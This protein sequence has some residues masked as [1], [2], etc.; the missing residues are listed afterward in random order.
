MPFQIFQDASNSKSSKPRSQNDAFPDLPTNLKQQKLKTYISNCCF[1]KFSKMPQTAKAQHLHPKMKPF[2]IF[3]DASN[4]TSSKPTSQ[5][6]CLSKSSKMPQAAKAQ[7]LHPK[8]ICFQIFQDAS[9]NKSSKSISQNIAF[10]KLP[11]LAKCKERNNKRSKPT[12]QNDAFPNLPRCLKQQK[13]KTYISKCCLS[14]SSK[15]PQTA[16]AQNLHP[17]MLPFQIFQDASSN[18]SS[19]PT[20]QNDAFPNLPRCQKQHKLKSYIPKWCLSK[21]SNMPKTEKA[22]N[23]HPK[24]LPF[25]N[26]PR[27]L[28]QHKLKTY[29]PK[30]LPFQIFQDASNSKSSKPTSPKWCLTIF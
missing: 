10:P 22:Q 25:P 29:I 20:S 3:Q 12:Y 18:K 7:N 2:Q 13:R 27:C 4:N 15:M 11:A 23:L 26:L 14:K 24:I 8:M 21:S 1:S 16:K 9:N 19:K 28:K 5:K 17:K 6:D 30:R